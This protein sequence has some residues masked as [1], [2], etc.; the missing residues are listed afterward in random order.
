MAYFPVPEY[1]RERVQRRIRSALE[2]LLELYAAGKKAPKE[3]PKE[4]AGAAKSRKK[5]GASR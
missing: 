5:G 3:K 4:K 2:R 1:E